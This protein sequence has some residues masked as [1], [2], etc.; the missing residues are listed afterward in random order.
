MKK[1]DIC[2][3]AISGV[4]FPNKGRVCLEGNTVTVKNGIPGQKIEFM[5]NKKRGGRLEGRLLQVLE[6]S[7]LEKRD[8][9]CSIFPACG[10]CMYQTM[11]YDDQLEMKQNQV[12]K[13]L[14]DVIRDEYIFEPIKRSPREFAYRNKMEFSF[15]D[16]YKDG[17]LSLGLHKKGSTYDVLTAAD[18]RL[19]HDD[20]TKILSCV[21]EFFQKTGVGYYKK[22]Q[23]TGY[24]RHL[25]LRRAD[26]TG[27]I[28]V[29]LVTTSQE[30]HDL[31]PL[32]ER[33]LGIDT[34]GKIVGI[35]HIINDSLSDVVKS[36]ETRILYGQDFFYEELLGLKFKITPFSFFQPNSGAAEVLYDTVREY[37]GDTRDMTVF[38]LYSGTGTISQIAAAVARRVVGVEIVEEA[39][40]AAKE[41][42]YLNG[43]RNCEFIA[44]DVLKVLDHL[45]EKPDL[46]ILD[47][48]RDGI[49]PK[50]LPKI[51]DYGVDRIV[52]ISCKPTS[53]AR[54]LEL[55]QERGYRVE[56]CVCF[57]QFVHTV[58]VETVALLTRK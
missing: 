6:K 56:R 4:D 51:L 19:V 27:E 42:A 25:L 14:D 49:H 48:P 53:L 40:E 15:G 3:G 26:T 55:I 50:A 38:D 5:I 11:Q 32:T 29:N 20:M 16:E 44:G 54:D 7:P 36:D 13:L 52:Y 46:I 9:V 34:Q 33:L 22:M 39:T 21:L 35:L 28:L 37:I 8:P 2:Q 45:N 12:K 41:N 58:H 10:G 17:P 23:H 31:Q 43:I 18:C 57:D 1:G 30:E 47:P 24:L